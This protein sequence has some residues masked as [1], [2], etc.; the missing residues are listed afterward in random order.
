[1]LAHSKFSR[2]FET[3]D[4]IKDR[5]AQIDARFDTLQALYAAKKEIVDDDLEREEF[6]AHVSFFG[7]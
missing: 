7:C 5:E 6:K 4:E 3:P 2:Q 1:L